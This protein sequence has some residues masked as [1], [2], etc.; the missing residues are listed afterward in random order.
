MIYCEAQSWRL[1]ESV[2]L[3]LT[4]DGDTSAGLDWLIGGGGGG[5]GEMEVGD[6]SDKERTG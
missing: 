2:L 6:K 5:G 4:E 1:I 3:S